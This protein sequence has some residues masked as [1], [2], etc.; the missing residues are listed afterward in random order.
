MSDAEETFSGEPGTCGFCGF[1]DGWLGGQGDEGTQTLHS[2]VRKEDGN[3]E[4]HPNSHG[5]LN[6]YITWCG[7]CVGGLKHKWQ[8]YDD[9]NLNAK[10]QTESLRMK[11]D[12]FRWPA[13]EVSR[14]DEV[15]EE[16]REAA[17]ELLDDPAIHLDKLRLET[18][19]N[20]MQNEIFRRAG[21]DLTTRGWR[22]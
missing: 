6:Q 22:E 14:D 8:R 7:G 2:S 13:S 11:M 20:D 9:H 19:I 12:G 15:S 21:F 4:R 18:D 1:G 3:Y 5:Y 17:K 10:F 16:A